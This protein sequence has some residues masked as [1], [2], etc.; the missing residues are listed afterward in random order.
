MTDQPAVRRRSSDSVPDQW[1]FRGLL[2]LLCWIPLPLGSNRTFAAAIVIVW[3]VL[4]LAGAAYAWRN[5]GP[6]LA[7]RLRQFRWPVLLLGLFTL[8]PWLQILPWPAAL[9]G[10]VSPE[11]LAVWDG[12]GPPRFTLDPHQTQFYAALSFAYWA[13]FVV[14]LLCVRSNRRLDTL[15]LVIVG[16]GVFQAIVG[17]LLFS[18]GAK[19]T[20]FF[21][22]VVHDR[23]R[24]T[25]VYHNHMAGYM[26]LCLSVG[27]GLM[28]A[29]LGNDSTPLGHWRSRLRGGID[30][31]LSPKMVLRLMLVIMVIALVLTR[32]RMGNGGFFAAMIVVG[33]LYIAL[34]RKTAPKAVLLIASLIVIDVVVI[35]TWV[36]LEK[37]VSRVQ[38]T[39]MTTEGGGREESVEL[40]LSAA[41]HAMDMSLDFPVLGTGAGS[42]YGTYLRYRTPRE[43]YFDHAHNDYVEI[44][45]D[46]GLPGLAVLGAFVALTLAAGVR[47][48]VR[49]RSSLPRGIA[50]GSLMAMVALIIHSWVDFNLQ[51]PANAATLLVIMA[52]AWCAGALPSGGQRPLAAA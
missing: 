20:M 27:I 51:I 17:A 30:F 9:I 18:F 25:F 29:R 4:L 46:F 24:G 13:I 12:I 3:A 22:E 15:A 45:A 26:E 31:M 42:F 48:L 33:L 28:L 19:Y 37:V 1:V 38:E 6:A 21:A 39:T 23:V 7:E 47:V 10:A 36:G 8:I 41:R 35:G 16:S 2:A 14:A 43:G 50:F 44:A 34:S 40:R 5:H 49:R 32:S 11:A 52:M